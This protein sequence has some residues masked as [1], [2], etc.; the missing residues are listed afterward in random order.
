MNSCSLRMIR[1]TEGGSGF[2]GNK[3]IEY[4]EECDCGRDDKECM[5]HCC[6]PAEIDEWEQRRNKKAKG[7]T[8][9]PGSRCCPSQ[10]KCCNRN[11][12]FQSESS[13]FMCTN[14]TECSEESFCNGLTAACLKP[15]SRQEGKFCGT[16][17][18]QVCVDGECSGSICLL[19]NMDEC[20]TAFNETVEK[21][22]EV[23]CQIGNDSSTCRGT[24][25]LPELFAEGIQLKPG[26]PCNDFKG[27]CDE[28]LRCQ[29][30]PEEISLLHREPY[31]SDVSQWFHYYWWVVMLASLL[32]LMFI[33][34]IIH[35]LVSH[36]SGEKKQY[37]NTEQKP[38]NQSA[39]FVASPDPVWPILSCPGRFW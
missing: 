4:G 39:V 8:L 14:V 23:A 28:L 5:D 19:V 38:P 15:A 16:G 17:P 3:I 20:Y 37:S 31:Q 27:Y 26:M 7:C 35:S 32:F 18:G 24:S 36:F 2:C 1:I 21:Q 33:A 13:N 29:P 11:C 6:Y 30:T 25:E 22:C 34:L 10:G 12:Q 9:R